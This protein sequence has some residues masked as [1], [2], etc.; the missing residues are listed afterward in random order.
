MDLSTFFAAKLYGVRRILNTIGDTLPE[1]TAIR[2]KG[3]SV[4]DDDD[5]KTTVVELGSIDALQHGNLPG[6]ALHA[7]ASGSVSGFM[8]AADKTRFDAAT[9]AATSNTIAAR[10]GTG[11]AAFVQVTANTVES[12]T[13]DL[14]L[15][16]NGATVATLHDDPPKMTVSGVAAASAFE[17]TA[18]VNVVRFVRLTPSADPVHWKED[19]ASRWSN[20]L[21]TSAAK[22]IVRL[23]VPNGAIIT[24]ASV[25]IDPPAH[26][27]A[28]ATLP[29]LALYRWSEFSSSGSLVATAS[30]PGTGYTLP[31]TTYDDAHTFSMVVGFGG[32]VVDNSAARY[33]LELTPEYGANAF[34]G[35]LYLWARIEYTMPAGAVIGLG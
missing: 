1:R 5:E 24:R 35:T 31:D 9:S 26:G 11:S 22:L 15:S 18:P 28:P 2:F 30:D 6:G 3:L 17:L 20:L 32:E 4:S 25:R 16:A 29:T 33:F 14:V 27:L 7:N 8:S 23:D 12:A 13:T 10:D 34:A 19:G 21:A